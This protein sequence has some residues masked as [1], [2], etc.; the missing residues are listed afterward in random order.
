LVENQS[1]RRT[2]SLSLL[3]QSYSVS[4]I[5]FSR[6]SEVVCPLTTEYPLV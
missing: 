3:P 2:L 4:L 5:I 6:I 1:N